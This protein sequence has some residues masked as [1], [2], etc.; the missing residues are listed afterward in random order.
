MG[1]STPAYL[2]L[3][4]NAASFGWVHPAWAES[5]QGQEEPWHWEYIGGTP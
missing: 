3:K 2:W 1:F 4:A 5:G